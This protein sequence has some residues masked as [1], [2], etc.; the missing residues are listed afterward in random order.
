MTA[1]L[2]RIGA[3]FDVTIRVFQDDNRTHVL[4]LYYLGQTAVREAEVARAERLAGA[5]HHRDHP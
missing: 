3:A 4:E 1:F 2:E 5:A